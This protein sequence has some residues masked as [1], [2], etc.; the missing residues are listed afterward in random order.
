MNDDKL[1]HFLLTNKKKNNNINTRTNTKPCTRSSDDRGKD[2]NR[3]LHIISDRYFVNVCQRL[4]S[5]YYVKVIESQATKAYF[6]IF[7]DVEKWFA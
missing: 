5:S 3:S 6:G 4:A 1:L 2:P 7:C